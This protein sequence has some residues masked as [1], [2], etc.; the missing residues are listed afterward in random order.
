MGL[1]KMGIEKVTRQNKAVDREL[2]GM[3]Q[4]TDLV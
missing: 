1:N 4:L 2:V 3:L